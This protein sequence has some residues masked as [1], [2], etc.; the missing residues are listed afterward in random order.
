MPAI[1]HVK[2]HKELPLSLSLPTSAPR[3]DLAEQIDLRL[4][5]ER[6]FRDQNAAISREVPAA[7]DMPQSN[8][9]QHL[10]EPLVTAASSENSSLPTAMTRIP[11]APA[12]ASQRKHEADGAHRKIDDDCQHSNCRSD[13]LNEIPK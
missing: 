6:D 4:N 12:T 2:H 7:A 3:N 13:G 10:A 5:R 9:V 8:L 11:S 1:D